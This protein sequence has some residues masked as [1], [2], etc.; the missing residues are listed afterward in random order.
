MG[1]LARTAPFL[2]F[3]L[4]L[5]LASAALFTY[6]SGSSFV[7]ESLHGVSASTY[8]LIFAV[9]AVGMLTA[10]ATFA[11]LS[12]RNPQNTV[13]AAGVALSAVGAL[14]QVLAVRVIGES[15]AAT[16]IT[17][18]VIQF[19]IGLIIPSAISLGQTPGRATPGAASALL[20]GLQFTL[21][22]LASPLVGLFGE[23]SSLPMAALMLIALVLAVLALV[24]LVR[25]ARGH[26]EVTPR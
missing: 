24:F 4:V 2:G 26:G 25:P 3:S 16:W 21:G 23:D 13:L 7:F 1:S 8:S 19:G 9:N 15:F 6:I 14:A 12:R 10:G 17:L 22:A 5:G 11:R 20:D 18:F